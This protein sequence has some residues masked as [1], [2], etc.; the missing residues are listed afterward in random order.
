M[1]R[2]CEVA[3]P[4]RLLGLIGAILQESFIRI[5]D[6]VCVGEEIGQ[7]TGFAQGDNLSPLL[8][9]LLL[10]DLPERITSGHQFVKVLLY[11]DDLV[12]FS[13]SRFHLQQALATL[14][15]YVKEVGLTVNT[16]KTEAMKFRRGGRSA[17]K[18]ELRLGGES[19]RYVNNFTYLGVTLSVTGNSFTRHVDER[20][21]KAMVA[22]T[23]IKNPKKL[24]VSTALQLFNMKIAPTASYGIQLIWQN[25]SVQNM[26]ELDKVKTAF[27]IRV[28]CLHRTAR[29]RLVYLLA[30]TSYFIED[31]QKRFSLPETEAFRA[32]IHTQEE[33]MAQIDPGFFSTPAMASSQW[34]GVHFNTRHYVTR[35]AVHGFHHEFCTLESFHEPHGG[36]ICKFCSSKCSMY[37]KL[38]C[39]VDSPRPMV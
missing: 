14:E 30:D 20:V 28:L 27:L 26:Q 33:K 17:V 39:L 4:P 37:H 24:S 2:L 6:G 38:E 3:V 25:L 7:T 23:S 35:Y 29:N 8:F 15:S 21:R 13:Q 34:K 36:C 18:D 32:F 9:S 31:L 12:L 22:F 10:A 1:N 11:A 16:T 5:D 19:L